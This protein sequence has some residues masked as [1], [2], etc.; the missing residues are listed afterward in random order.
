L[1]SAL[2]LWAE[3]RERAVKE[4]SRKAAALAHQGCNDDAAFYVFAAR[5]LRI[6][7]MHERARAAALKQA[8]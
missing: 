6:K 3:S 7:A 2:D 1:A 8:A 5:S 4:L